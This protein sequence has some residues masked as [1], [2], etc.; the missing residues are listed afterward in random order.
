MKK[1]RE[2]F[3][4]FDR[5]G[6][7]DKT[8][9]YAPGAVG[10]SR[11]LTPEGYMVCEGVAIARTGEQRYH[12][13]E[14]PLDANGAGEII[15]T[16][17]ADEVFSDK[18]MSSFEGKPVTLE[19]PNEFVTPGSWKKHSVGTVHNVRRGSGIEDDTL[20]GDLIITDGE[21]IAFVNRKHPELSCGYD[22]EYE[23]T[24]VGRAT[25]YNIIGNH[26]ALL[27]GRGR[28]GSRC[29]IKDSVWDQFNPTEKRDA[30]GRWSGGGG[31]TSLRSA[32]AHAASAAAQTSGDE[33]AH[34]HALG[35]HLEAATAA[36]AAGNQ[37]SFAVH[38]AKSKEHMAAYRALQRKSKPSRPSSAAKS[39]IYKPLG[40]RSIMKSK[41]ADKFIRV[42]QAFNARDAETLDK[43]LADDDT[44]GN[45]GGTT[46]SA[47]DK[48][49]QDALAWVDEQRQ[50][51]K[52][53]EEE[54]EAADCAM[55]KKAAEDAVAAKAATDSAAA[56]EAARTR[57]V[58]V[59]GTSDAAQV[60]KHIF[61]RAEILSPGIAVPTGDSAQ[62]KDALPA[63]MLKAVQT[64]YATDDGKAVIEPFLL[65]EKIDA[66]TLDNVAGV[67][68]GAAELMRERN[69]KA[70]AN[71]KL[72][73]KDFGK[74]VTTASL[75]ETNRKFWAS[76]S[77]G[78]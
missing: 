58:G 8:A 19:H 53:A 49:I 10:K 61:A 3:N 56:L 24:D 68:T 69:N 9:F 23:Q 28:A 54:Q 75:N 57:N 50:A 37:K 60:S 47:M 5:V 14:L 64:A 41:F 20:V 38:T 34:W 32:A 65:G 44:G 21:A 74:A 33:E 52:D 62:A 42:M 43:E 35:L 51:V 30:T 22:A 63:L 40:D 77:G 16:R 67:F 18:T 59:L 48:R 27:D 46:D 76:R 45:D 78:V 25:Q 7:I 6:V 70:G 4:V 39:R 71:V 72:T 15:V 29:A 31:G 1:V 13:S 26:V 55:K 11:R 73:V 2:R 17:L 12:K 36:H 66:V